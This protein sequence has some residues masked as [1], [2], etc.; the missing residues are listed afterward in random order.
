[1]EER[2]LIAIGAITV[3][4]VAVFALLAWNLFVAQTDSD[5]ARSLAWASFLAAAGTVVLAFGTFSAVLQ[6]RRQAAIAQQGLEDSRQ[7]RSLEYR[8][9][10]QIVST[11]FRWAPEPSCSFAVRNIGR[12]P[13]LDC[14]IGVHFFDLMIPKEWWGSSATFDVA[15]RDLVDDRSVSGQPHDLRA[16]TLFGGIGWGQTGTGTAVFLVY[17][18][19]VGNRFLLA[20]NAN[21][22][23]KEMVAA[24]DVDVAGAP[25]WSRWLDPRWT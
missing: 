15:E 16:E 11:A 25:A 9:Q 20:S 8:P 10:M 19:L 12:G 3:A 24:S 14:L 2:T 22:S 13:A 21:K 6:G 1:M 5:V 17:R 23:L 4:V 7:A 18:D